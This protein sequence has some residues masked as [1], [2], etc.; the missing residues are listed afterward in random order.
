MANLFRC[1][2]NQNSNLG[3]QFGFKVNANLVTGEAY[4]YFDRQNLIDNFSKYVISISSITNTDTRFS[5][6][7]SDDYMFRY[8]KQIEKLSSLTIDMVEFAKSQSTTYVGVK[9]FSACDVSFDIK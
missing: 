2:S 3:K 7:T 6:Y 5:S 9:M 1:G 8:N 4:I